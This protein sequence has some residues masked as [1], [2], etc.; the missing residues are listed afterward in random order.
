MNRPPRLCLDC[1]IRTN[2]G[3][4]CIKC[5]RIREAQRNAKRY[6]YRGSY[7]YLAKKLR[8]EVKACQKCGDESGPFEVDHI[9]PRTLRG[10]LQLL[11][12]PCH[13]KKSASERQ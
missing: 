8:E 11:C 12:L 13:R 7:T 4:R 6:W 10:G 9:I 2:N 5:A 3:S 1:K